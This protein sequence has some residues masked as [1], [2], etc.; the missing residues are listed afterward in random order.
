MIIRRRDSY[1][2]N[3]LQELKIA[4]KK[5]YG[6]QMLSV[7]DTY[8]M[9]EKVF[10]KTGS[11][12][13]PA[14][15]QRFFGL[16][17]SKS[18]HYK[19][20]L[21]ILAN[22]VGYKDWENFCDARYELVSHNN[23][24]KGLIPDRSAQALLKICLANG[25]F[26]SV[27][28]YL[29]I[30]HPK[31]E[32]SPYIQNNKTFVVIANLLGEYVRNNREEARKLLPLL[33][34]S[35]RGREYFFETFVDMDHMDSYFLEALD[36]YD[37]FSKDIN[38]VEGRTEHTFTNSLRLLYYWEQG[39][40][41]TFN[42]LAHFLFTKNKPA[43]VEKDRYLH[44]TPVARF[45]SLWF[46]YA[47]NQDALTESSID[48]FLYQMQRAIDQKTASANIL[49]QTL[50]ALHY[51]K[52]YNHLITFYRRN[53]SWFLKE[54]WH[55]ENTPLIHSYALHA[56]KVLENDFPVSNVNA[57]FPKKNPNLL[58]SAGYVSTKVS[59]LTGSVKSAIVA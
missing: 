6:Q 49:M 20:T 23:V 29:D 3:H 33:A 7:S 18:S 10:V 15:M 50:F 17:K 41:S 36:L 26:K 24:N 53:L 43:G 32:K 42:K 56:H 25:S 13:S 46:L 28:D 21:N 22:Y 54:P 39:D 45:H 11:R 59:Q 44:L 2:V 37:T 57:F 52:L 8:D 47:H 51:S 27:A 9:S 40:M 38:T 14:T 35:Q 30:L 55:D 4:V 16:I 5:V 12:V 1:D 48:K 19:S 31:Y 58:C 34:K